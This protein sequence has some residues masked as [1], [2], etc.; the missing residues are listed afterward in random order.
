[1]NKTEHLEGFNKLPTKQ[2]KAI[3]AMV[4]SSKSLD[5]IQNDV[6]VSRTTFYNWRH[7][8]DFINA[9]KEYSQYSLGQASAKAVRRL[10][11]FIDNKNP[12][13][14]MQAAL[15]VIN[16]S[17][18]GSVEGNSDLDEARARKANAEADIAEYKAGMVTGK[19]QSNEH[20]VLV[21]DLGD[22]DDSDGSG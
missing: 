8:E 3:I 7:R 20:T 18:V 10:I 1:M 14:A 21:D 6:H 12:Y 15:A 19:G 9:L 16:L 13:L 17:N 2:R 22:D 4:E 5:Q 11:G